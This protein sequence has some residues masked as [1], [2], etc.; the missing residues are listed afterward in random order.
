MAMRRLTSMIPRLKKD[1][2][3]K[4]RVF[5]EMKKFTDKGFAVQID[6]K[7][8]DA[9]A[10]NPRWY[11]PIHIVEKH[12]KTRPCHDGRASVAGVCLNEMLLGGPNLMNSPKFY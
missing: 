8:D 4:E 9:T 2:E 10:E 12:G 6:P 1:K 3:R 7:D 5:N 11:L